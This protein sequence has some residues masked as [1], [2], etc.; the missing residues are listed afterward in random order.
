MRRSHFAAT[1]I[2]ASLASSVLAAPAHAQALDPRPVRPAPVAS[3]IGG[4][5]HAETW[6]GRVFIVTRNTRQPGNPVGWVV[7]AMRP[8][9]VTRIA[10]GTPSFQ[11]AFSAGVVLENNNA[12][13]TGM[14]DHNAL[15]IVPAPGRAENPF[16]SRADGSPAANGAFE[17]YD[18]FIITQFY[19]AP[20][21]DRMG[22]RPA[23]IV[24]RDPHTRD[25]AIERAELTGPFE[26]LT[27]P[28]GVALRGIEPTITFDGRLL[29]WQGHPDNDGKIDVIVYSF[30]QQ[31]AAVGGWSTPRSIADLFHRDRDTLIAG[32]PLHELFPIARQQLRTAD[33]TPYD[34]SELFTG[35]YPWVTLDGSELI[36]M[37]ITARNHPRRAGASVIGRLTRWTE[38]LI[39][40][41]INPDRRET[42][43]LFYS[44]PG[45]VPGFWAPYRDVPD[46][47]IPYTA[48]RPV[49]P[50]FGTNTSNYAE[51]SFEDT[52][53]DYVLAL[54]GNEMI[55]KGRD[56]EVQQ[57]P[58]TSGRLNTGLLEG[59]RF[60]LELDG[61]DANVGAAG[62][63]IHFGQAD[64]VR[65]R[66]APSL[67]EARGMLTVQ[68]WVKR[69]VDM[70][71]D[72]ENRFVYL[73]RKEGAFDLILEENGNVQ[74]TVIVGGQ[75]K[76]SGPVGPALPLGQ[77][78]HV[79]FTWD[80]RNG[81]MGVWRD[82]VLVSEQLLGAGIVDAS[83]RDLEI[84]PSGIAPAAPFVA[85]NTPIVTIDEV[86]VSRVVR[87]EREL[88]EAAFRVRPA[89]SFAPAIPLPIG[90]EA[91]DL[92]IP[93]S[94]PVRA[95]VTELGRMLF[96]DERLSRE[97]THSC[98]T[99]HDPSA[100]FDD[101]LATGR[102][103]NGAVLPRNSP[104]I[105][106]RALSTRQLWDGRATSLEDQV[107]RPITHPDE[108][109]MNLPYLVQI[110]E[111][112]PE[113]RQRFRQATGGPANR[114]RIARALATFVRTITTG[115]APNDRFEAGDQA[116]L[117]AAQKRGR[118]L[119]FGKARCSACHD[120]NNYT[121]EAFHATD[122][123]A[124][125][126][127]GRAE[128]TG[129]RRDRGAFKTPTLRDVALTAPYFHD[130]SAATLAE[131]VD[132][133]DE[134]GRTRT[135]DRSVEIRPLLLSPQERTDLVAFLEAL[136]GQARV[137]PN[138]PNLPP[139]PVGLPPPPPPP[140][141]PA[142]GRG[143]PPPLPPPS[144]P[145]G[146][147]GT[148]MPTCAGGPVVM[149]API[150]WDALAPL[151]LIA[152]ALGA[153][154]RRTA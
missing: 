134:G 24:V 29:I 76:R 123:A 8:E 83:P 104:T 38:R 79:A 51:V 110:L 75:Q 20:G 126:D 54:R 150:R 49:M 67:D 26:P 154:R 9:R 95:D 31:P 21:G 114:N 80:G 50:L 39:D 48:S 131:V 120:G 4:N 153:L 10:N 138:A 102:G 35:A 115:D 55:T 34:A 1:M 13:N 77:W 25:A 27:G 106:N 151:L 132:R 93:A 152:L 111:A 28:G 82:G 70:A 22:R 61:T 52:D 7:F 96:F 133:Y 143:A 45:T 140:P 112:M 86:F 15:A 60:P 33:G 16:R 98:A 89:P 118:R 91:S 81:A 23:R 103:R 135:D 99:C 130:G 137:V 11:N 92:R 116:A 3:P 128:I 66:H 125:G 108:M 146:T 101:G 78:A 145:P 62:Q 85:G 121:D 36:Y 124:D 46:V 113:Y 94:S 90:L 2:V 117:N 59:A 87:D 41:P 122:A 141:A 127:L 84:G 73:A 30:N 44:S 58:D 19:G 68:M 53:G 69:V 139:D 100:G 43:R 72:A 56:V 64:R 149:D 74:A 32:E 105:A 129:R 142:P 5:G 57:T 107:L 12:T 42:V 88:A 37:S 136:T 17:T 18:A 71:Q 148:P 109:G 47:P 40:G 97:R 144:A 63:A 65:V 14:G 6:D 147:T 119:F